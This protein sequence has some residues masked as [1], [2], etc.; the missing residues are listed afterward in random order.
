MQLRLD[1]ERLQADT[2]ESRFVTSRALR[3]SAP[4]TY[5][6]AE[7]IANYDGVLL[8]DLKGPRSPSK[9][10]PVPVPADFSYKVI[11]GNYSCFGK[12]CAGSPDPLSAAPCDGGVT[13]T[14]TAP[15]DCFTFHW[16]VAGDR[17]QAFQ[18]AR[19]ATASKAW[20]VSLFDNLDCKGQ[21]VRTLQPEDEDKCLAFDKRVVGLR[22]TPLWNADP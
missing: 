10:A 2:I 21:A 1:M 15:M 12:D 9:A 17:W 13:I 22:V 6:P 19:L 5:R 16:P 18:S 3:R 7:H 14:G 11:E 20:Q 4:L 8:S